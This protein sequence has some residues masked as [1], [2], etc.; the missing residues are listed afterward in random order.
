[1]Y[2]PYYQLSDKILLEIVKLER[3]FAKAD[4]IKLS[5]DL[6]SKLTQKVK[7][8]NLFH[9]GHMLGLQITLRDAEKLAEGRKPESEDPRY[10]LLANFR[11]VLEFNRSGVAEDYVQLNSEV[12]L[13]INKIIINHWQPN[14][15]NTLRSQAQNLD[16]QLEGW[17]NYRDSDI[18]ISEI[19]QHLNDL[20]SWYDSTHNK[21]HKIIRMAIFLWRMV[22][23]MPFVAGN[24]YTL[25]AILDLLFY[26]Y[27]YGR[28]TH[29]PLLENF[30]QNEQEY[31]RSWDNIQRSHDLT[32][33]L[34][35]FAAAIATSVESHYHQLENMLTEHE[36][37][38][39]SQPF[40]DLNKRQLKI[41]RYL[42]NIPTVKRDDYCQ[43]MDVST[44]TAY[45]DLNDLVDKKLLK[46]E[47]QGRGTRYKLS[48]R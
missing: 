44:M 26:Q 5:Y 47:G 9:L 28:V 24:K 34:E 19:P 35:K 13:N 17:I 45:R 4:T 6:R 21:V 15:K 38:N 22:E 20:L 3:A 14:E 8:Q 40:L 23:L 7:A 43:M 30:D 32:S 31:W 2:Q 29:T 48:S 46:V 27:D 25:I 12:L 39:T 10:I 37:K 33:W 11:N 18:T 41:L 42:Q 1:M 36:E 16:G